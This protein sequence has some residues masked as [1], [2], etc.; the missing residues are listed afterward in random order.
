[1]KK[2]LTFLSVALMAGTMAFAQ[3]AGQ[4]T[5]PQGIVTA[6]DF[7]KSVSDYY[8]SFYD[9]T[10][11]VS[12]QMGS[13][14]QNGTMYFK[15]PELV[16]ID[17]TRPAGEVFNFDGESLQIYLPGQNAILEQSV[18][19]RSQGALGLSLIRRYYTIQYEVSQEPV[20]LDEGS[21]VMVV[22]LICTR[23]SASEAFKTIKL[24]ISPKSKLIVRAKAESQSGDTYII[25][26]SNYS[27]NVGL[28]ARR[29]IYDAPSSANNFNN[30]LYEE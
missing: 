29:F 18:T 6:S 27:V 19:G 14:Y 2:I 11:T 20:P 30:F 13:S 22:N 21:S 17:F 7:F 3:S 1:M 28:S 24:S 25:D 10:C 23:R 8:A 4:T 5:T 15:R 26:F 12:I 16:R 9:Y